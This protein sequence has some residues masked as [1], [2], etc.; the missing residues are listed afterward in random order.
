MCTRRVRER[1]KSL[2]SDAAVGPKPRIGWKEERWKASAAAGVSLV[3]TVY[4]CQDSVGYTKVSSVA[5]LCVVGHKLNAMS[6]IHSTVIVS[7]YVVSLDIVEY[8]LF[9][10]NNITYCVR[11]R[12]YDVLCSGCA[13]SLRL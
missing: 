11:F 8:L 7:F 6:Y 5:A 10:I 4:R 12:C 13:G 1:L 3:R 2:G 9:A